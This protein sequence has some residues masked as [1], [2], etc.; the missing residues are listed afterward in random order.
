MIENKD[1]EFYKCKLVTHIMVN[2]K[3][4]KSMEKDYINLVI[5]T[6]TMESLLRECDLEKEYINGLMA[7]IMM[8]N[9]KQTRWMVEDFTE[10]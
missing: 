9:G 5:R 6:I 1:K 3:T 7:V 4:V 8:D 2:G 10:E